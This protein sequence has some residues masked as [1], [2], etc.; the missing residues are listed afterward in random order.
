[1]IVAVVIILGFAISVLRFYFV[2][3]SVLSKYTKEFVQR[4]C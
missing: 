4:I 2:V 1:M 3:R